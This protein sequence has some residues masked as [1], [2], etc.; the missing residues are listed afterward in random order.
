MQINDFLY[1]SLIIEILYLSFGKI[2]YIMT[3]FKKFIQVWAEFV[4]I[5]YENKIKLNS[6][7]LFKKIIT[8]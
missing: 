1:V 7:D 8:V 5:N 2:S 6:L 4:K 3:V